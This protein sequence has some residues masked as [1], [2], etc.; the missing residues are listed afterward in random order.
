MIHV[1]L[2]RTESTLCLLIYSIEEKEEDYSTMITYDEKPGY[3][4]SILRLKSLLRKTNA[5]PRA[6]AS[7]IKI[8]ARRNERKD[9]HRKKR[10]T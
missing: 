8:V 6:V 3:A 5:E 10:L 4:S 1:R 7:R 9:W 2:F